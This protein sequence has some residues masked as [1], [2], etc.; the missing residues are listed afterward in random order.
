MRKHNY[1]NIDDKMS[2]FEIMYKTT[3]K[4]NDVTKILK[5]LIVIINNENRFKHLI[6]NS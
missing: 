4:I 2:N 6:K 1:N 5:K 3:I